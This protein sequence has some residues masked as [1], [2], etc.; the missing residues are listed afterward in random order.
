MGH[1]HTSALSRARCA[2]SR[3]RCA[4]CCRSAPML[5]VR[6]LAL[7]QHTAARA[8]L[9]YLPGRSR[10]QGSCR[11]TKGCVATLVPMPC[12]GRVTAPNSG[13]DPKQAR[14]CHDTNFRSPCSLRV[15]TPRAMSRHPNGC[16]RHD[17]KIMC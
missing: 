11:D 15:A 8:R 2:L 9:A 1:T 14:P 12:P 17:M 10:H 6:A 16:P 5:W 13:R 3:A 4:L 7:L